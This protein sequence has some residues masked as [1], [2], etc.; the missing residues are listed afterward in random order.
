M[1][2]RR[3]M[4]RE[5]TTSVLTIL[6]VTYPS[7]YAKFSR[8]EMFA[9]V[10]LWSEMFRDDDVNIVKYAL[11]ELISTH[12]G[13]PPDIAKL[14]SKMNEIS[15]VATGNNTDEELWQILK[16]AVSNGYYG[17]E[18]EFEKLPKALKRYCGTA[19]TLREL[20]EIDAD[21]FNTVNH[22][23]FLKQISNIRKREEFSERM[24][25]AVKD[26]ITS[27]TKNLDETS[28]IE[29]H[30]DRKDEVIAQLQE[31]KRNTYGNLI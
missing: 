18:E 8:D 3:T 10:D 26:Y 21:T 19:R 20:A 16:K 17:S 9:I 2:K 30:N 12:S 4:T 5:D 27:A 7:F 24:P 13:F 15:E 1:Q 31:A 22:G 23:Q 14:K 11:K 6:K 25:E 28:L 29:N